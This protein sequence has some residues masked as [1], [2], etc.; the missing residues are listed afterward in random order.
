MKK[1]TIA[2]KKR[3]AAAITRN[4]LKA[5]G[6][7]PAPTRHCFAR[8]CGPGSLLPILIKNRFSSRKVRSRTLPFPLRKYCCEL[9]NCG[10]A[11]I[12]AAPKHTGLQYL[13]RIAATMA[14]PKMGALKRTVRQLW[15]AKVR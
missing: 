12:F 4:L 14:H 2:T 8:I 9:A 5:N 13:G 3:V 11:A 10:F 7:P 6:S 1:Q 15:A